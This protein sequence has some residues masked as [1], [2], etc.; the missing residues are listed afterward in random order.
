MT[1]PTTND[2]SSG[3]PLSRRELRKL[4][5]ASGMYDFLN[6]FARRDTV[7]HFDDFDQD[8]IVLDRYA[9][10]NG[11][12]ASAASFATSVQRDGW[13]R[14]TTGTANGD[15][16]SASLI[17]PAIYYGDAM[18]GMEVRFKPIT[19]ITETKIEIG[20]VD[21][22]PGS[23]KSVVNSVSTPSVN[24]SVVDAA[25]YSYRHTGST[26]TNQLITIGTSISAQKTNFT[27]AL[28]IAAAKT[29]TVRI[30]ISGVRGSIADY[31]AD[32]DNPAIAPLGNNVKMW[33]NGIL[34]AT[35]TAAI[36]G[37]SAIAPWFYLAASDTTS[38]SLDIDYLHRW[39]YRNF[40]SK[41]FSR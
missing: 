11:G 22:V 1:M 2:P 26:T 30:Q 35:H 4:G 33:F 36:E 29:Y 25:L 6:H 17:G 37:G 32:P 15:T 5:G 13:I 10:A 3:H 39:Q 21:V 41:G 34:V 14:A 12:G 7:W 28:A 23:T 18:C 38:K 16:A 31:D 20:F 9:V 27:P 8:T 24:T 40:V 19:A